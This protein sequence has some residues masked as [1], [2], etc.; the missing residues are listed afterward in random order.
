MKTN[1]ILKRIQI[2]MVSTVLIPVAVSAAGMDLDVTVPGIDTKTSINL[3]TSTNTVNT[4]TNVNVASDVTTK[5]GAEVKITSAAQVANESDLELLSANI[6]KMNSNVKDVA[7]EDSSDGASVIT[8]SYEHK[9]KFLGLFDV[10]INSDT[11]VTTGAKNE[12]E[13]KSGL[14][15]WSFLVTDVNYDKTTLESSIKNNFAIKNNSGA[16]ASATAKAVI[17]ETLAAELQVNAAANTK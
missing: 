5:G 1:K 4:N 14:S 11:T 15:W 6:V 7:V 2:A 12:P 9:G 3:N 10:N 13:V 16:N 8:V 17:A